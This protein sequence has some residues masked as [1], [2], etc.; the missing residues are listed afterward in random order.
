MRLF[1]GTSNQPLATQIAKLLRTHLGDVEITRFMDNECRVFIRE[2]VSGIHVGII[3]SLS[4]VA[5][6]HLVELCL[7]GSAA[8]SLGATKVTAI[9]PWMGY[10][11]QDKAFRKGE[12]VSAQ[13]VAQFIEAA[14]FDDVIA[15]ELHSENVLPYFHIPVRE[16]STHELLS[17][18]L[19]RSISDTK[20]VVVVSPDMGGKSRS[21]RF[22]ATS[23]L[24]IVYLTK[25]RTDNT[26][27]ITG[28]E[29]D[30]SGKTV[31]VFDDIINTGST[32]IA[33][34]DYVKVRG[35]TRVLFLATHAVFAGNAASLLSESSIDQCIVT[36]SIDIPQKKLFD[37][38]T[39]V[40]VAP[41]LSDA[42]ATAVR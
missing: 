29:G 13:L 10:S 28:I 32:A 12:A 27:A 4:A 35:A 21:E 5:D 30:V 42:I 41:L 9:I 33:V 26:V 11:K 37:S 24:P 23:S 8:K 18:A 31:I 40:S 14:G 7:L 16:L 15:M 36:N 19:V 39:V 20:D 34:S 17:H 25:K 3:Q 6:Q 22:A 2:E 1:S 38:L